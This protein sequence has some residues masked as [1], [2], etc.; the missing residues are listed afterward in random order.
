MKSENVFA[1]FMLIALV[2]FLGFTVENLW[3]AVTKGYMD[4]RNMTLPFLLGYGLAVAAIFLLFGTPC[5]MRIGAYILPF[6]SKAV[7][8]FF[9]FLA[10]MLCI[11]AGEIV[12]GTVV[13]KVCGIVW[14]DYTGLPLH[15]TKYT[16]L[17][18]SMGFTVIIVLF[19]EFAAIP[20]FRFFTSWNIVGLGICSCTLMLLMAVDF[21]RS[22]YLMYRDKKLLVTWTHETKKNKI[23]R[24]LHGN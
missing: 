8:A 14:W 4:N 18:T 3:M 11:S 6:K 2:S 22:A 5:K 21:V 7:S 15:I 1:F 10:V 9:Y 19:M 12:L 16:S 17:F 20:L 24:A 23:Y 13:E